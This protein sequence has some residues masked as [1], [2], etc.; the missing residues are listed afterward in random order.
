MKFQNELFPTDKNADL[1]Q[2]KQKKKEENKT[3][4]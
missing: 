2:K 4:I 1:M 3:Q